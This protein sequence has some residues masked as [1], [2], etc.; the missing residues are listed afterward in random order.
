[1]I[2][3]YIS[4]WRG[5]L[6]AYSWILELLLII[7]IVSRFKSLNLWLIILIVIILFALIRIIMNRDILMY[8]MRELEKQIWGKPL[9]REEWKNGKPKGFK[10]LRKTSKSH[11]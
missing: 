10:E 4:L 11:S 9:D 7:F 2:K 8:N 1:M 6:L 3:D 5:Y